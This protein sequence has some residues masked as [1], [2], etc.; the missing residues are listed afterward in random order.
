MF[1]RYVKLAIFGFLVT[2]AVLVGFWKTTV[3][4]RQSPTAGIHPVPLPASTQP[5]VAVIPFTPVTGVALEK[6]LSVGLVE[7]LISDLAKLDGVS[8]MASAS[9][10]KLAEPDRVCRPC[11]ASMVPPT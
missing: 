2:L 7:S 5:F 8:V 1:S 6:R 4:D 3:D 9:A 11:E 10:N